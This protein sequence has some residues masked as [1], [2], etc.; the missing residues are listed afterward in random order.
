[1]IA[2]W[3]CSTITAESL[4]GV[5]TNRDRG[6]ATRPRNL[7]ACNPRLSEVMF[8]IAAFGYLFGFVGL[9]IVVPLAA[10]IGVVVRFATKQY[11]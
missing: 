11:L 10:A 5:A 8:A 1:V 2:P 3:Q 9:L 4:E 7:S 6:G